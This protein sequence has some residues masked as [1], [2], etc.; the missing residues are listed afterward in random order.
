MALI[1]RS[2]FSSTCAKS[3]LDIM[4]QDEEKRKAEKMRMELGIRKSQYADP[5]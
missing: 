5:R 3:K 1:A 4:N 2:F